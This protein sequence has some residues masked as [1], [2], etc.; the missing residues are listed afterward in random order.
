[1]TEHVKYEGFYIDQDGHD[2]SLDDTFTVDL[3]LSGELHVQLTY[4]Q[5]SRMMTE[6]RGR[7]GHE[8]R[9]RK[10]M[11]EVA[12]RTKEWERKQREQGLL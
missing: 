8:R 5:V 11:R 4:A 12:R 3:E 1:M 2:R 9:H 10:T 7:R 6:L